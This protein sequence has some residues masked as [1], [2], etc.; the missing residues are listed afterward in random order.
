MP[1]FVKHESVAV[2]HLTTAPIGREDGEVL[3]ADRRGTKVIR[4]QGVL[5]GS[6]Q[7][8]L[9]SKIDA[10]TEL[11]SR[12][13]KNLDVDW[14]GGTRRYVATC[15]GHEFDRDHFHL[16]VVPWT[17]EFTVLSGEGKDTATTK[18]TNADDTSLSIALVDDRTYGDATINMAGGKPPRPTVTLTDALFS[19]KG[20]EYKNV[21]TGDRLIVTSGNGAQSIVIDCN[22]RTVVCDQ[23]CRFYGVFPSWVIGNNSI[24]V[25]R[26][27]VVNQKSADNSI[28]DLSNASATI[29]AT[30][31]ILAQ[32]FM[33]PY[34]D[35][36]FSGIQIAAYKEG[37]PGNITWRIET[38]N[39][40][41]PS[42]TLVDANATGTISASDLGLTA[43]YKIS[44][45]TST[46][47]FTLEANTVY[48]LVLKAGATLNGSNR[49]FFPFPSEPTYSRG[50]ARYSTDSGTSWDDFSTKT[51]LGFQILFGG[52]AATATLK[53]TIAYNKLYL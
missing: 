22:A 42:G 31:D 43:A 6:S 26:G 8:D 10:F 5:K 49:Y 45:T 19:H 24:R 44:G 37:A 25:T 21:T 39:A 50:F 51:D 23:P 14:N 53:H 16:S 9:E 48:W 34:T 35:E 32:S 17:A 11:F 27:Y 41:K 12:P 36:T 15:T 18:P 29:D 7:A 13:E 38:D 28:A 33:V 4:V 3:I 1:R 47:L 20:I 40:G 52:R 30:T 46:N 2:R